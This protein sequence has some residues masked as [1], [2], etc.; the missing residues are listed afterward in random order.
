MEGDPVRVN[1]NRLDL[2]SLDL[3]RPCVITT[4]S[5]S[6]TLTHQE[7]RIEM[8]LYLKGVGPLKPLKNLLSARD[9]HGRGFLVYWLHLDRLSP[10]RLYKL[11]VIGWDEEGWPVITLL[12]ET[13]GAEQEQERAQARCEGNGRLIDKLL[14]RRR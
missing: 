4:G 3:G 13:P 5:A 8:G 1:R 12:D 11:K 9:E 14:G 10:Q 6:I 7:C 2:K